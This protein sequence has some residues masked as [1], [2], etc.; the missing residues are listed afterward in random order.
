MHLRN[1]AALLL[2]AA[3]ACMLVTGCKPAEEKQL[4]ERELVSALPSEETPDSVVTQDNII[5]A[6]Y[7]DHAAV[8]GY[9]ALFSK[10]QITFPEKVED[11]P[12]T[13]ICNQS[14]VIPLSLTRVTIPEGVTTIGDDAFKSCNELASISLPSSLAYVGKD[15]F[16]GTQWM[17]SMQATKKLIIVNSILIDGVTADGSADDN[18]SDPGRIVIPS[19]VTCIAGNAFRN[20]SKPTDVFIPDSVIRIGEGAF[21]GCKNLKKVRFGLNPSLR[22][23]DGCAFKG[24]GIVSVSLPGKLRSIGDEAF[25]SCG[26]LSEV[27]LPGSLTTIGDEAFYRCSSLE[28]IEIPA[29]VSE[30]GQKAFKYCEN[31]T[32]V[33]VFGNTCTFPGADTF[34]A[35][36]PDLILYGK[37]DSATQ[38]YAEK[39][40]LRFEAY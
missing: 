39:C 27:W 3:A 40:G 36:N 17:R 33:A 22:E 19:G 25:S 18:G 29:R 6:V 14:S 23:I 31:L 16:A 24:S 37:Q 21:Q 34:P 7:K 11:K 5:Y 12:L 38:S 9:N 30:I 26:F 1:A 13:E 35:G 8:I 4:T 28:E 32:C 15:A 20:S 2:T 10:E